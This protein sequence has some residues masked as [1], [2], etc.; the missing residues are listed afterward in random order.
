MDILAYCSILKN[1]AACAQSAR[2]TE[3]GQH[4]GL[5]RLTTQST[6][7]SNLYTN[8]C[9]LND[10]YTIYTCF[11]VSG[12]VCKQYTDVIALPM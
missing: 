6:G 11:S 10:A 4:S 5:G 2:A 9:L 1:E 7:Y 8:R 12:E 3:H